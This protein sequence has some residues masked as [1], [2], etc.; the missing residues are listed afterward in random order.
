MRSNQRSGTRSALFLYGKTF[1]LG[2]T[3]EKFVIHAA[4]IR[5]VS[6]T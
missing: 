4:L 5:D 1:D 3:P 2:D 6:F